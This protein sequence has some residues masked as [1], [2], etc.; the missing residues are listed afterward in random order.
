MSAEYLTDIYEICLVLSNIYIYTNHI[1]TLYSY[2]NNTN[3]QEI[4]KWISYY[5]SSNNETCWKIM[6]LSNFTQN[7]KCL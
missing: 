4:S 5:L 6:M 2:Y 7:F 1:Q 3:T